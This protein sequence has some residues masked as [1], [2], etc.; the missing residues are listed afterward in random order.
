[1]PCSLC[2]Q[3]GHNKNN[4]RYHSR[5]SKRGKGKRRMSDDRIKKKLI[6]DLFGGKPPKKGLLAD[7][8]RGI[9]LRIQSY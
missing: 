1:M 9:D 2:G 7:L 4:K 8:L 6:K 5:S 3:D